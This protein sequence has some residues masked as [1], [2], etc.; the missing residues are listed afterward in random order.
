[1]RLNDYMNDGANHQAKAVLAFLQS[2][3]GIENSWDDKQ[4]RYL[5][6]PDVAR[7]ENCRE[8]GYVVSMRNKAG[9]QL[10]IAFFEHR[11]SDDICA[12]EWEQNTLNPPNIDTARFYFIYK[13]K[14]DVSC[15]FDYG[16]VMEMANWIYSRLE[17]YWEKVHSIPI[18]HTD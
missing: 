14:Y 5:A 3:S 9:N 18:N 13:N 17:T 15:S 8:Q 6:E 16:Q 7:W 2:H 4:H 11:N 12:V 1:M 10:N